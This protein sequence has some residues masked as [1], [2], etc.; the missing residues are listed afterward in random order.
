[1]VEIVTSSHLEVTG[2]KISD[3][4]AAIAKSRL[5]KLAATR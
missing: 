2:G 3:I 1:M 4:T 5:A